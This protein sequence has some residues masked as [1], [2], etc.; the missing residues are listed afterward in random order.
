MIR[1]A[2]VLQSFALAIALA[3]A[4]SAGAVTR[5]E[6][7]VRARG[8]AFHPWRC[9]A[10]NLRGACASP[11]RSVYEV[12]DYLG[13]PYDWGGHMSVFQ[14]DQQMLGGAGA[15]SYPADGVL[16]CT[17]GVDCSGFVS[18]CWGSGHYTTRSI[19]TITTQLTSVSQLLPGDVM[20]QAGYHV[21]MLHNRVAS[22]DPVWIEAIGY[23]THVNASGG[24]SYVDGYLPRRYT[25]I[26]GTTDSNPV[27]STRNPIV[28]P[29]LPYQDSR[30]TRSSPVDFYD[31]CNAAPTKSESGPEYVYKL[32]I[33]RPGQ[34]TVT[35]T[36]DAATDI[37]VHLFTSLSTTDCTARNDRT[38]TVPVDCGTYYVVADTYAGSANAG[39]YTLNVSLAPS[40]SSACGTGGPAPYSFKGALGAAC[41][42]PGDQSL[43]FCNEN[44]GAESCIYTSTTSFCSRACRTNEDCASDFPGGCCDEVGS[45]ESYCMP[46]SL[47]GVVSTPDAGGISTAG[48]DAGT[49]VDFDPDFDAGSAV[50]DAGRVGPAPVLDAGTSF[51]DAGS[52]FIDAGPSIVDAG[53]SSADAGRTGTVD[54]GATSTGR[55]DASVRDDLDEDAGT[56]ALPSAS[57]GCGCSSGGT[58]SAGLLLLARRRRRRTA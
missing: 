6:V 28:I 11:Y 31:G 8:F 45:G 23:N 49:P 9:K 46:P 10:A 21:A 5:D 50:P 30:D 58:A 36:D 4:P 57:A 12:G 34:L 51:V 48:P 52:T 33:T 1:A 56:D 41:A 54:A 13:L 37:D 55:A 7:M 35:V 26:T 42:Y 18:Q 15:G 22:G 25:S 3:S 24:W 17:A 47:C 19:P 43:P 38:F 32:Q 2:L 16:A 27:G 53:A 29:S 14:F 40:A 44:L 39:Q 20:N